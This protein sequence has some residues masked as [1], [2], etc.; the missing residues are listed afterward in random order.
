M[1]YHWGHHITTVTALF[2]SPLSVV[3]VFV[4]LCH[5]SVCMYDLCSRRLQLF[6]LHETAV[7]MEMKLM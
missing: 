5:T 6:R 7:N 4:H 3:A 1:C 2:T